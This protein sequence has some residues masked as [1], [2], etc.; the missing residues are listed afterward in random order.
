MNGYYR[1]YKF[2][3]GYGA[4]VVSNSMSYGGERGLFEVAVLNSDG[5]I[6]YDTPITSEVAGF[7]DFADVVEVLDKIKNLPQRT[8]KPRKWRIQSVDEAANELVEWSNEH[9]WVDVGF[10]DTF[11]DNERM[12]LNLPIGGRWVEEN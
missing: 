3:N 11:D 8:T 7:L 10:G 2:D 1:V 4:S 12:S 6:A 5:T 9:G